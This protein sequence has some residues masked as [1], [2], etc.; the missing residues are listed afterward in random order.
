MAEHCR[1][2]EREKHAPRRLEQPKRLLGCCARPL[3]VAEVRQHQG[4][5]EQ[6]PAAGAP[7]LALLGQLPH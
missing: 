1:V 6:G 2:E 7:P 3:H 4:L 5:A